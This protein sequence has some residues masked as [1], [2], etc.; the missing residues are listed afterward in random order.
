M[1]NLFI[2]IPARLNSTRLSNKVLEKI[3]GKSLVQHVWERMKHFPNV[4]IATDTEKVVKEVRKFKGNVFLTKENHINGTERCNEVAEKLNLKE[5]DIV[6]NVQCDELNIQN[7]WI[8]N[9]YTELSKSKKEIIAT[10]TTNLGIQTKKF[11]KDYNNDPSNVQVLLD[12]NNFA[13]NFRR[14]NSNV[15]ESLTYYNYREKNNLKVDHHIGIY[16]YMVNTLNKVSKLKITN[17]EKLEKLEQLRWLENNFQI[18]C[19]RGEDSHFGFSINTKEDLER[20]RKQN[21]L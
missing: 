17:R 10:I 15:Y 1:E 20:L 7:D 8:K 19:I 3:N 11:W 13:K 9:I 21:I 12:V 16:G 6:I 5:D 4:L 18:K 14:S 2:I